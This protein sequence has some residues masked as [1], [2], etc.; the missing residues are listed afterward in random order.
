MATGQYQNGGFA[1]TGGDIPFH[2]YGGSDI[3]AG[4]AVLLDTSNPGGTGD[5]V[6]GVV[7]PTASG[8]VAGQIGVTVN[9]IPAG[10]TGLVRVYG[11]A[12]C[13]ANGTVT[14]GETVMTS[15]TTSKLGYVK[16]QTTAGAQ[17]GV[18]IGS[19]TDGNQVQV[20]LHLAKNA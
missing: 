12:V 18:A 19:A 11:V 15:D 5:K 10:K 13:T 6:P 1:I 7:L 16:T 2:N 20:L 4:L 9:A 3:G 8:G 17:L 14:I